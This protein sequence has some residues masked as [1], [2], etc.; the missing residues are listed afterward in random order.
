V[1]DFDVESG[2]DLKAVAN[3]KTLLGPLFTV[4]DE[5]KSG[6]WKVMGNVPYSK[7]PELPN[8]LW[9]IGGVDYHGEDLDDTKQNR[10]RA[11]IQSSSPPE[12]VEGAARALRG[13][14]EWSVDY[15]SLSSQ[16]Q[17]IDGLESTAGGR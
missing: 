7:P 9:G 17:E 5:V 11:I 12:W 13:K 1:L 4:V 14:G 16:G 8:F 2:A 10:A 3:A 15:D 6:R